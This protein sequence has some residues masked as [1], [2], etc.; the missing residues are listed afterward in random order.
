MS[1]SSD[2]W[3]QLLQAVGAVATAIGVAV[4]AGQLWLQKVQ[5][6][7]DFEDRLTE[8]YRTILA[9]LPLDAL[10]DREFDEVTR[11]KALRAFY[12]YFDLTNEQIF[13][14]DQRRISPETWANWKEGILANMNRK[15]FRD[16]WDEIADAAPHAFDELRQLVP[17][18]RIRR[19]PETTG[20]VVRDVERVRRAPEVVMPDD[21]P[22][23]VLAIRKA[24][25]SSWS[26]IRKAIASLSG[27][28]HV[29]F[30]TTNVENT[31]K[32]IVRRMLR[33]TGLSLADLSNIVEDLSRD[34]DSIAVVGIEG[35]SES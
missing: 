23:R 10:L 1:V 35:R 9:E 18:Q 20:S 25:N 11:E 2:F 26:N 31:S 13:L 33:D 27:E 14:H 24:T 17:P 5:Q 3:F 19:S 4:A 30:G 22:G 7:T 32:S 29:P 28:S 8:Q 34:H 6:R 15:A 21:A 16:A 12:R